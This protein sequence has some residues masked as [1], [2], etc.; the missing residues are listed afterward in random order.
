MSSKSAFIGTQLNKIFLCYNTNENSYYV[1]NSL[2]MGNY[3]TSDDSDT[4]LAPAGNSENYKVKNVYDLAGNV[5][6]WSL[7]ASDTN[8]RVL[9]GG[10]YH[11][12]DTSDTRVAYRYNLYPYRSSFLSGSRATLY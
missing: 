12:A 11:I 10:F 3:G 9:R 5:S 6:D 8:I 1:I 2:T 7:E 4:G